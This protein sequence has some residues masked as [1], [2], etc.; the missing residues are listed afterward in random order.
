MKIRD[1]LN[2]IK[3]TVE[4]EKFLIF[5]RFPKTSEGNLPQED[6]K[7]FVAI[8]IEIGKKVNKAS[9]DFVSHALPHSTPKDKSEESLA[10]MQK[11]A[12]ELDKTIRFTINEVLPEFGPFLKASEKK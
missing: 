3:G 7:K 10:G 9:R 8:T 4:Y 6:M 5:L 2:E 11:K 1:L 12:E